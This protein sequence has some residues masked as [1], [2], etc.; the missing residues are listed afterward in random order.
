MSTL[1]Y[2]LEWRGRDLSKQSL[3]DRLGPAHR[4]GGVINTC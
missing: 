4:A 3:L 1:P 2:G